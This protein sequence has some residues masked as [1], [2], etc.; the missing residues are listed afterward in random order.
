MLKVYLRAGFVISQL[1]LLSIPLS[2]ASRMSVQNGPQV[3]GTGYLEGWA[4]VEIRV[5]YPDRSVYREICRNPHANV[6]DHTIACNRAA[7]ADKSEVLGYG[8]RL[9]GWQVIV[10]GGDTACSDPLIQQSTK[11][12][13]CLYDMR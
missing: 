4:V 2:T 7:V 6:S 1:F 9:Y 5:Y 8:G 3:S 13:G 12:I 11:W 10:N